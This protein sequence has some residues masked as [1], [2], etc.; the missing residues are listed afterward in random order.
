MP[1][2]ISYAE[3]VKMRNSRDTTQQLQSVYVHVTLYDKLGRP[4]IIRGEMAARKVASGNFFPTAPTAPVPEPP[5]LVDFSGE[6]AASF[7]DEHGLV[8]TGPLPKA[9]VVTKK[10]RRRA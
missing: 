6:I 5:P 8:V 10:V 7:E 9:P 4:S 1:E 2:G 3:W